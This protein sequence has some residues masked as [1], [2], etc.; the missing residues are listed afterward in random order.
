MFG[1]PTRNAFA[2]VSPICW[3]LNDET[4]RRVVTRNGPDPQVLEDMKVAM[5]VA[6]FSQKTI[7]KRS[8]NP[9]QRAYNPID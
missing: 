5:E 8:I 4:Y 7:D 1:H 3:L 6:C 2:L 9:G